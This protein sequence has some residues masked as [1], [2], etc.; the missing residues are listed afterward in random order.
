[1]PPLD[2]LFWLSAVLVAYSYVGYPALLAAISILRPS[3]PPRRSPVAPPLTMLMVVHDEAAALGRKLENCLALDYP[4]EALDVL[5]VSDGSTDGTEEVAARFASRGVRT[6]SLAGPRGKAACIGEALPH[7]RGEVV[8]LCDVR[9]EIEPGALRALVAS[10]ADPRVG[11]VSGELLFR[12]GRR[13]A[14]GSGLSAYWSYEKTVRRLESRVDSV[15]GVTGALYAVRRDLL[16]PPDPRTILDDVLIPMEVVLAGYRV[17]FEPEARAWDVP[18]DRGAHEFR[19]KVRT[20]AGNF[21]L[22]EIRPALLD[23][24]QNRLWWQLVSHKLSRLAVPWLLLL[25]LGASVALAW[26]GSA[27]H[28][29]VVVAGVV[30]LGLATGGLLVGRRRR[31]PPVLSVPCAFAL[32]NTAAVVALF[33]FLTGRSRAAWRGPRG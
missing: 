3:P 13:S 28:Q 5:V 31:A 1:M 17:L 25:A 32:L 21:Q 7:C 19:R 6:L 10:F 8:V 9:Q 26:G 16:R 24:R 12:E 27:F 22:L 33:G 11:A 30:L 18:P 20:L 23:P 15:V 2:L 4:R 14:A 29:G